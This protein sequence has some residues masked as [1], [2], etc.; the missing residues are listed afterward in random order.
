VTRSIAEGIWKLYEEFADHG[1]DN[2]WREPRSTLVIL[3]R[4]FDAVMPIMHDFSYAS[5][6]SDFIGINEHK[7]VTVK[8]H[9]D[10]LQT[11]E[12]ED[13]GRQ[14]GSEKKPPKG[15]TR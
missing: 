14:L 13:S 4:T 5:Q 10:N 2:D 1:G 11:E 9:A 3:D 15:K 7:E 12:E 8:N 6:V